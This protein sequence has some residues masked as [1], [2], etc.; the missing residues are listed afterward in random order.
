[1]AY[2]VDGRNGAP[3]TACDGEIEG[4]VS[5]L[6]EHLKRY[7]PEYMIPSA[8]V[9]LER[10]PLTRNGKVDRRKLPSP[11]G[12]PDGQ[13]IAPRTEVERTLAQI[14][15]ELLQVEQVGVQDNFFELGGHSLHGIRLITKVE[16]RLAVCLSAIA[17]FKCPT[18]EQ[19]A[20]L[21]E[22]LRSACDNSSDLEGAEFED[23]I[24]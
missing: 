2:V 16:E 22:A 6:R 9:S 20:E 19:M 18:V 13:Y 21:V 3:K 8:W 23:G 17:V 7:L 12:R 24:I 14:W 15:A 11:Q 1:V 4:F 5:Q 10:L